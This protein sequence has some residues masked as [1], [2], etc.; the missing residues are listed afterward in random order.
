VLVEQ[1]YYFFHW[2]TNLISLV[3]AT[4]SFFVGQGMIPKQLQKA[5]Q[6]WLKDKV[7]QKYQNVL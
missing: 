7:L 1:L 2:I 4:Y 5:L 6:K 3:E